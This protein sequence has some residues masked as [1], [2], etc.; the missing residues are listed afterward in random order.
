M[1]RDE[2]EELAV[3]SVHKAELAI[4]EPPSALGNHVED[5]LDVGRRAAD[6]L[7]HVGGSNLLLTRLV[8]LSR[9]IV[10]LLPQVG[11]RLAA[12]SGYLRT[13][14]LRL[15]DLA[16]PCFHGFTAC[17]AMPPHLAL[18]SAGGRYPITAL[19]CVVRHSK[20]ECPTS[21]LGQKRTL[22]MVR[23]MSAIPPKA[24][25]A[26]RDRHDRFAPIADIRPLIRSPRQRGREAWTEL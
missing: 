8:Q 23:P 16:T 11:E 2:V 15:S 20:I 14:P 12:A 17:G 24:D 18:Q 1:V 3:K 10:E 7:E 25:I 5:R 13:I 21:A 26:E 22:G 9:T 6:D 19:S 4:A